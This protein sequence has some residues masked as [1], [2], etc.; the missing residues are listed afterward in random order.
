MDPTFRQVAR[1]ARRL[2]DRH[3]NRWV[4]A[5]SGGGDSVA[6][7]RA[8]VGP[9]LGLELSVAHLDHG[10]RGDASRGDAAFVAELA[11][12]L[13]LP[14][15]LGQWR[16]ERPGHFEAD[17]RR[18]RYDW[19]IGVARD[20]GASVVAVGHNRDDQAETVL[21]RALR[22]TGP[23]GL[24]GMR[25]ARPLAEGVALVRPLLT[26]RAADLRASLRSLGQPWREDA[27]N[28]DPSHTR[29]RLRHDILPQLAAAINPDAID[30]LARL[31]T[32]TRRALR[33]LDDHVATLAASALRTHPE[34][35]AVDRST[36]A[37]LSPHLRAEVLRH[38]WRTAGWPEL[39]MDRRRW[40]RLAA[41]ASSVASSP[42]IELPGG[43]RVTP[44][45]DR[46]ALTRST[47]APLADLDPVPLPF[48]GSAV[49]PGGRVVAE[50]EL[51]DAPP[52][53]ERIDLDQIEGPLS[54]TPPHLGDRFD[55][56]GLDGHSTPLADLLRSRRVPK[57]D[58]R[59]VPIVR[60]TLGI[61]WV[62]GHRLAQRVRITGATRRVGRLRWEVEGPG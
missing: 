22:G 52:L 23:R 31:G 51:A 12:S 56:L 35:W 44:L 20:R 27:T 40:S 53:G 24:I 37:G 8:L 10:A 16:A 2:R 58:R 6:M 18:A 38:L 34:G 59:L 50:F 7:L 28:A 45:P 46:L 60:D 61:V 25:S 15:D 26:T 29:S 11:A 19:L 49:W 55:P 41:L 39:G 42:P 43:V 14:F 33:S 21:H 13:G 9:G 30:A 57:A 5:V 17:A 36:L 48:P 1:R 3:G 62:V 54:V 47:T 32:L 4:V